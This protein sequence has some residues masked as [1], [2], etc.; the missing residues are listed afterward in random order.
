MIKGVKIKL[1]YHLYLKDVESVENGVYYK[2]NK[3]CLSRYHD[4]FDSSVFCLCVDNTEDAELIK[5]GVDWILS[6]GFKDNVTIKI[7]PNTAF[8]DAQTFYDEIVDKIENFNEL[9]FFAHGKGCGKNEENKSLSQW[10]IFSYYAALNDIEE[11]VLNLTEQ[12]AVQGYIP[13]YCNTEPFKWMI[14]GTIFLFNPMKVLEYLRAHDIPIPVLAD[15]FSAEN[16][17]SNIIDIRQPAYS[18][19]DICFEGWRNGCIEVTDDNNYYNVDH[20]Y[21]LSLFSP[22]EKVEEYRKFYQEMMQ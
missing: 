5:K 4:I 14:P 3:R 2:I 6:C 1:V 19:Y 22:E 7:K 18:G 8:N 16:F 20:C 13:I 9:I 11:K 12:A 17:I 21:L 10:T 15:R